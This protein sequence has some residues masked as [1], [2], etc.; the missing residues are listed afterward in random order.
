MYGRGLNSIRWRFTLA[1]AVLTAGGVLLR[2]WVVGHGLA[3]SATE[4]VSV[5]LL[6]AV[7][8]L[9]VAGVAPWSDRLKLGLRSGLQRLKPTG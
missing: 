1:C 7:T 8:L 3:P 2:E 9:V 6:V 5:A 4:I